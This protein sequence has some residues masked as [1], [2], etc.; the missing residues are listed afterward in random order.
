MEMLKK[1][2]KLALAVVI[3]LAVVKF[4]RPKVPLLD[5]II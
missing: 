3:V 4:L 2:G 1:F 5:S